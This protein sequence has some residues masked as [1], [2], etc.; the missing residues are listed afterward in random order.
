MTSLKTL[1]SALTFSFCLLVAVSFSQNID[2]SYN[3]VESIEI[4]IAHGDLNIEKSKDSKVYLKGKYDNETI[5]VEISFRN[6]R[7]VIKEDGRNRKNNGSAASD[8]N[9]NIPNGLEISSN[10]GKGDIEI[11]GVDTDLESN[12]GMG[13]CYLTELKGD[14]DVNTGMGNIRVKDS[15]A[16]FK[17][18]SGMKDIKI[19]NSKG[20]FKANSGMGNVKLDNVTLTGPAKLNSGMGNVELVL[21][22]EPE[23]DIELNSGTGNAIVDFNGNEL[24]GEFEM[25]CGIKGG[26]IVAPFDFSET[27]TVG[28]KNNGHIEKYTKIGSS[29]NYIQISTGTGTAEVKK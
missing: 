28:S 16:K 8:W 12:L 23:G 19:N 26:D 6:G 27:K 10:V 5:E 14:I 1:K 4:N 13:D 25:K 2:E 21:G 9:L 24:S 29:N 7:L 18:N 15:D 22:N 3:G 11:A 20:E 17:L